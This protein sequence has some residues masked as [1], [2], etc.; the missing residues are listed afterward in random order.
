MP[1]TCFKAEKHAGNCKWETATRRQAEGGVGRGW[2]DSVLGKMV[3]S[4]SAT[5][6]SIALL[7]SGASAVF[8]AF[9]GR[10]SPSPRTR[11]AQ[12][13]LNVILHNSRVG[14]EGLIRLAFFFH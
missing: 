4:Q 14:G 9:A 3:R 10:L 6:I 8:A 7:R 11:E 5:L 2:G 1:Q 12:K 13:W